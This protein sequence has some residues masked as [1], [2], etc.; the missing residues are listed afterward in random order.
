M[1]ENE[2][3]E[4]QTSEEQP[5]SKLPMMLIG[6]IAVIAVIAI[7]L[8]MMM[9]TSEPEVVVQP[10]PAEYII[11]DKMYQL[12]DGSYLRLGFSIV[13]AA[14]KLEKVKDLLEKE[15]PGRLP[16]GVNMI[17]GNKTR[18]DLISGTH[19]REAFARELKKMLEE[20]V[21]SDYNRRQVVAKDTIQVEEVLIS[22]FVTQGG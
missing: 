17:V 19:K 15:A 10:P 4:E 13:V 7:A 9:K 18:G 8:V 5:K 2:N 3:T 6:G 12:K 20:R 21:F 11:T 14:E 1:P 16:D 22:D